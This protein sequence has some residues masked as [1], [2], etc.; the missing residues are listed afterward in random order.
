MSRR[1]GSDI[2][3]KG[4]G[5]RDI[6]SKCKLKVFPGQH[7]NKRKKVSGNYAL[8]LTAKQMIKYT[9][10]LLEKQFR[11]FYKRVSCKKGATGDFL[12]KLNRCALPIQLNQ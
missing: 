11:H 7:G 6:S 3:L 10:G 4:I 5:G 1:V 9:Y 12:L 8:Q 2:S